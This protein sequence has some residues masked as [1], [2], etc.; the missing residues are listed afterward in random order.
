VVAYLCY[1]AWCKLRTCLIEQDSHEHMGFS[2]QYATLIPLL[3]PILVLSSQTTLLRLNLP[4][5]SCWGLDILGNGE[6]DV[7][8]INW[9]VDFIWPT[10]VRDAPIGKILCSK[11]QE[12]WLTWLPI[13]CCIY[14]DVWVQDIWHFLARVYFSLIFAVGFL[15]LILFK[16]WYSSQQTPFPVSSS[17][18][19]SLH[20]ICGITYQPCIS[21]DSN[22]GSE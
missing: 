14:K 10:W 5:H 12:L 16:C 19:V 18:S 2:R 6:D 20:G 15:L 17:F 21:S 13:F 9:K 7:E 4:I 8:S 3:S 22:W 1:W 11:G